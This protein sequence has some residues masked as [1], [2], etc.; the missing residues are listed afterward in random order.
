M[1]ITQ[2]LS[3][4][5]HDTQLQAVALLIAADFIFGILA[6]LKANVFRLTY[7]ANLARNDV[8]GKVVPW[9]FIFAF[10]KAS[11]SADIVGPIDWSHA[12]DA[13][14]GLVTLAL[15][16]SILKSLSDLGVQMPAQLGGGAPPAV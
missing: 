13:V 8:L 4:F 5:A 11:N 12:N 9:F 16:G 14:F 15:G 7:V 1:T 2:I 3:S 10:A 6:A